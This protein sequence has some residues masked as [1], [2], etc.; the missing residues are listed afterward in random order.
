VRAPSTRDTRRHLAFAVTSLACEPSPTGRVA[1]PVIE[2]AADATV[3][4]VVCHEVIRIDQDLHPEESYEIVLDGWVRSGEELVDVRMTWVDTANADR[5]SPFGR[6]VRRHL[7][8]QYVRH[9]ARSWT[10]RM[11]SRAG[12]RAFVIELGPTGVPLAYANIRTSSGASIARCRVHDARIAS[13]KIL[14]IPVELSGLG[15]TCTD[16]TGALREGELVGE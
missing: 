7:D 9:D 3:P 15:V 8:L 10:V 12:N 11:R 2:Q 1:P 4:D 5:R 13:R 6:G 16:A 14:G